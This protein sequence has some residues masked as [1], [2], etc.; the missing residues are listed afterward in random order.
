MAITHWSFTLPK[1]PALPKLKN[2]S[3][4]RNPI[5]HFIL[6]RLEL[7]GLNS[8][9]EADKAAELEAF[10]ADGSPDAY[11][12]AV[13]HHPQCFTMWVAGRRHQTSSL[14][15]TPFFHQVP[16]RRVSVPFSPSD[17]SSRED[18]PNRK[19]AHAMVVNHPHCR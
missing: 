2:P 10:L 14:S 18:L 1:R 8:S 16:T 4:T 17:F 15:R 11:E 3:W 13:D 7:P 12:K 5:D 9:P 19:L 6:V